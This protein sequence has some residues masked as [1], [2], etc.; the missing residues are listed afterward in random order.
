MKIEH[1]DIFSLSLPFK[2]PLVTASN[3]FTVANGLV[4]KIVSDGGLEGYGYTDPF[5]RTGETSE[6]VRSVIEKVIKPLLLGRDARELARLN[7]EI[8]HKLTLNPRAKS[9]V[10]TALFD[11]LARSLK[12]PL[13]AL[14]GGLARKEIRVIRMVGLGG[15]EEMAEEAQTLVRGGLTALKLKINGDLIPDLERISAVRKVV[16]D[17]IFIKV[18]A[19]EAYDAKSAIRLAQKM[20]ALGVELFE[21]P[22]PRHQI[23]ALQEVKRHSPVKIEADQ[24]VRSVE[25]AYQLIRE[26]VADAINTS[27][28]KAGGIIEARKIADLCELAGVQCALSNTAGSMLGDAAALH[29]A[30]STPGISPLCEI[31]EFEGI[32]GDPF[33]GLEVQGGRLQVPDEPGVGVKLAGRL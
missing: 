12:A 31:G 2:K 18:D 16:G 4:V 3:N 20:A 19:N 23:Q 10:Q 30:V 21:Q 7:R 29:L 22:V 27:V 24:S 15:P 28:Q 25:D 32:K 8:N 14:L 26:G 13:F 5:P 6:T 17:R 9:A 33:A 1:I 11:L